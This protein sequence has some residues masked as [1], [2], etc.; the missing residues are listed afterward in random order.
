M[1]RQIGPEDSGREVDRELAFHL[2][3]RAREFE[4]E[5][6]SPEDARA[7]ARR[8]FGDADAVAA[9]CRTERARRGRS[10]RLR[11]RAEELVSDAR[12]AGRMLRRDPAFASAAILVLA[13]GIGIVVAVGGLVDAYLL[14]GLPFPAADRLVWIRGE[15]TPDW[16]TAPDVLELPVSW[17]LDVLSLT[18]DQ[19]T[20]A[21]T[22]W[23]SPTYFDAFGVRVQLGRLPRVDEVVPGAPRVALISH[24]L[25]QRRWGGDP[26]VVGTTF[27]A[28]ASDRPEEAEVFTVIGVLTPDHWHINRF[29]EV[30]SPLA[31]GRATYLARLARGVTPAEAKAVL[32]RDAVERGVADPTTEVEPVHATFV[33]RVRPALTALTV[34][35]LLVL[36]IAC[37][38]AAVLL[39][40][41]ASAREREFSVRA[42]LGAGRG[43][44]VRQ[45]V[46]EGLVLSVL[47]AIAGI[48]IGVLLLNGTAETLPRVLGT[49]VPGGASAL[50]P[51][52]LALLAALVA[53]VGSALLFGLA[54][55]ASVVR[56]GLVRGLAEGGRG[57]AGRGRNRLRDGLIAAEL[58]LSLALLVGAGLLIRSADHL[59]R[60]PLGFTPDGVSAFE[61]SIRQSRYPDDEAKAVFY[62]EAVRS[63]ETEVPGIDAAF[64]FS[65]PLG[66]RTFGNGA[67]VETPE[68]PAAPDETGARA[69]GNAMSPGGFDLLGIPVRS[70]RVFTDADRPGAPRVAVVGESLARRLWGD[71]NPIG[72][73][74]RFVSGT[75]F[76]TEEWLTVVGV[77]GDVVKT[78]TEPNP[79]DLYLPI[80]QVGTMGASLIVRSADGR[81][82]MDEVRSVLW[83]L[84]PE[85][86][87]DMVRSMEADQRAATLPARFLAGVLAGF[88]AFAALLATFG[89]YGA[90][91]YAVRR[92]RR[93][94]AIRMALGARTGGVVGLFVRRGVPVLVAGLVAGLV[95]AGALARVLGS[96][97]H[98]IG[99]L[100]PVTFVGAAVLLGGAALLAT[101][102]P[103]RRATR[104]APMRVLR[105]D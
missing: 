8:A 13:L 71:A 45:L 104:E 5:G 94:I 38:N 93:D 21:W 15:E 14:R 60:T 89:L 40:V 63:V 44:L 47:A 67:P 55:I 28:Y 26:D 66:G 50:R 17:D 27:T 92:Q 99:R 82:R 36:L 59:Q 83:R 30:L 29:Y 84:D 51:Q 11:R 41:R 33:A 57:G 42:A 85:I 10:V 95:G 39:L 65:R 37:G 16:R 62:A 35:V 78:L 96:Q 74:V 79:P 69:V 97:I 48:A 91:S 32:E 24:G 52:G 54:P 23:V 53:C 56:P 7:A 105:V 103:A 77:V 20:R 98:G 86:P 87:L 43:R 70:G 34:S 46:V 3:M 88:A 61:I 1:G 81:N 73:R 68:Q 75:M 58:A 31:E 6:L 64:V 25:W 101:I 4:A 9:E 12:L 49:E 19:P 18:G 80:A 102:V 100:D 76:E 22:S 72:R 2:E 90:V